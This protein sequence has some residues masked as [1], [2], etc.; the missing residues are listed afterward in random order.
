MNI[1]QTPFQ[2]AIR[3]GNLEIVKLLFNKLKPFDINK[4][5]FEKCKFSPKSFQKTLFSIAVQNYDLEM[6][7][8]LLEN[9]KVDVNIYFVIDL[10]SINTTIT[11]LIQAIFNEDI[12]MVELLLNQKSIDVNKKSSSNK[13]PLYHAIEVKNFEIIKSLISRED[14]NVNELCIDDNYYSLMQYFEAPVLIKAILLGDAKLFNLLLTND[15]I[16]KN[17]VFKYKKKLGDDLQEKKAFNF[18]V[19]LK[20]KE[21]ISIFLSLPEIDVNEVNTRIFIDK[22]SYYKTSTFFIA[23]DNGDPEIVQ[24]LL[25]REDI[26]I[27]FKSKYQSEQDEWSEYIE[28]SCLHHAID[29]NNIEIV[30][31]LLENSRLNVND[32]FLVK[33]KVSSNVTKMEEKTALHI[34]VEKNLPEIVRLLLSRKDLQIDQE[35]LFYKIISGKNNKII[36]KETA[37]DMAREKNYTEIIN[38]LSKEKK[39]DIK[40]NEEI[41][42]LSNRTL[43]ISIFLL[44]SLLLMKFAF[45]FW[46]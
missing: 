8:Y 46:H 5:L 12:Q 43:V 33:R 17:C 36:I 30:R 34:A 22:K 7:K 16:D 29:K 28:K 42:I 4:L 26:D 31:V 37:L 41:H 24:L 20:R 13:T 18:S 25:K 9:A 3:K 38:L 1:E 23:C 2:A 35:Y 40:E 6:A 45:R 32:I 11:P 19:E 39:N 44:V 15:N 10:L 27:N 14:V 21:I